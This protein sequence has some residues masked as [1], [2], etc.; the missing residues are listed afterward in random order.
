MEEESEFFEGYSQGADR[1]VI[2]EHDRVRMKLYRIYMDLNL[3]IET[4]RFEE[5]YRNY[6]VETRKD[7][8]IKLL[9]S[10]D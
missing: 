5:A 6:T 10:L 8:L 2:T 9:E 7:E 4:Y 1:P 3:V